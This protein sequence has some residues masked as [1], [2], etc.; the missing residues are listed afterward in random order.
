MRSRPKALQE[1][2]GSVPRAAERARCGELHIRAGRARRFRASARLEASPLSHK[3]ALCVAEACERGAGVNR[4]WKA[5]FRESGITPGHLVCPSEEHKVDLRRERKLQSQ[6]A[7]GKAGNSDPGIA[8][9]CSAAWEELGG[10]GWHAGASRARLYGRGHPALAPPSGRLRTL[11][12]IG[13]PRRD[14]WS[15]FTITLHGSL[16]A[17]TLP[18]LGAENLGFAHARNRLYAKSRR[19]IYNSSSQLVGHDP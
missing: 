6:C 1:S 5:S 7:G 9:H 4:A 19:A 16:F 11:K 3:G 14:S 12:R 18:F 15:P 10:W 17:L 2:E 8:V 13:K